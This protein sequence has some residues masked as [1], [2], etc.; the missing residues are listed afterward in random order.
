MSFTITSVEVIDNA[1]C[2][3]E[4]GYYMPSTISVLVEV[5]FRGQR[6]A[7]DFQT[8][9]TADYGPFYS[10]YLWPYSGTDDY[11]RLFDQFSGENKE[12]AFGDFLARVKR[13]AGAQRVWQ[14]YVEK[15]YE[16]VKDRPQM[17]LDARTEINKMRLR[18]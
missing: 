4:D 6:Y 9:E 10:S 7:L 1:S 2:K 18:D 17:A 13:A 8:T 12:D 16:L 5:E 11:D 3:D 14:E 15:N